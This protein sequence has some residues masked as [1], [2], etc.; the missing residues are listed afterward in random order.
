MTAAARKI[1]TLPGQYTAAAAADRVLLVA[2][3]Q[4]DYREGKSKSGSYNNDTIYGS[5]YGM[6]FEPWCAMFVSWCTSKATFSKVIIPKHAYTPDGH[7]WFA[8]RGLAD[9]RKPPNRKGVAATGMGKPR[10][11]DVMYVYS[12]TNGRISHVGFV[13]KVLS[14]GRIQTIEG[15]TDPGGSA[16]GNGVYRLTRQVTSRL[17]FCHPQY[18]A[19]VIPRP[20]AP[21][22]A[23]PGGITTP[24]KEEDFFDMA[25]QP[26][27]QAAFEAAIDAKLGPL[28]SRYVTG[29]NQHD[30][31]AEAYF[32]VSHAYATIRLPQ[33]LAKPGVTAEQAMATVFREV[34]AFQGPLWAKPAAK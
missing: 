32:A 29:D 21:A 20:Q 13:E 30:A 9:G 17:Y 2:A 6:N 8:S 22:P 26:Q 34:W 15:N 31:Q 14:G 4:I 7:N 24:P 27:V 23:K 33:E 18:A 19:V 3:S 28:L 12:A 5:W 11:G 25:T 1:P 16:T 10:R